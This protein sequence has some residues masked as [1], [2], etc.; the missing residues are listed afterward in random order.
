VKEAIQLFIDG[1]D[2]NKEIVFNNITKSGD[3]LNWRADIT[4]L[5]NLGFVPKINLQQG[6]LKTIEWLKGNA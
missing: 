1:I 6:L 4:E 2:K 5:T 3:P